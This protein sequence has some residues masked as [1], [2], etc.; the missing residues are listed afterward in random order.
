MQGT[1]DPY[2]GS[3]NEP[4]REMFT[5]VPSDG[6]ALAK[7]PRG[8]YVGGLGDVTVKDQAG[9]SVVFKAVPVG[10]VLPICPSFIMATGTTATLMIGL[11]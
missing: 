8:L 2:A 10:T 5:V 11:V 1:T 9:T 6:V 7:I 3:G 4:A